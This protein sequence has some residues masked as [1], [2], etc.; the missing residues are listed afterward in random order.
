MI[1]TARSF[2]KLGSHVFAFQ[3]RGRGIAQHVDPGMRKCPGKRS[4]F[5]RS[6]DRWID[7]EGER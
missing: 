7:S 6:I 2:K 5:A 1:A 4:T 3:G